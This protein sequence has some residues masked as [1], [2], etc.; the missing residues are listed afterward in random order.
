ML[1]MAHA[2]RDTLQAEK[3]KALADCPAE[4]QKRYPHFL[5]SVEALIKA[6]IEERG[7][8]PR[9]KISFLVSARNNAKVIAQCI[10][11]LTQSDDGHLK[12]MQV[13]VRGGYCETSPNVPI[14]IAW[15]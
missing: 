2:L 11:R 8:Y 3:D 6:E 12:G 15:T 4:A 10:A 5:R 13:S 1:A 7:P 9:Y 14:E